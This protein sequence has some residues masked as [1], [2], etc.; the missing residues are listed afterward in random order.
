MIYIDAI[1]TVDDVWR[2][3]QAAIDRRKDTRGPVNPHLEAAT[4]NV[5]F[6]ANEINAAWAAAR[7]KVLAGD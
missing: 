5:R 7:R 6:T 1:F 3:N 4:R 2:I